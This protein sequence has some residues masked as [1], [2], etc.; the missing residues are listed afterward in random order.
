NKTSNLNTNNNKTINQNSQPLIQLYNAGPNS[1]VISS[2]YPSDNINI[3]INNNNDDD[4]DGDDDHKNS[5]P[6]GYNFSYPLYNFQAMNTSNRINNNNISNSGNSSSVKS[7]GNDVDNFVF[8]YNQSPPQYTP[9][10][11]DS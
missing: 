2:P 10:N 9:P 7:N 11:F 5:P 6:P 3:N 4:D 1:K 8:N